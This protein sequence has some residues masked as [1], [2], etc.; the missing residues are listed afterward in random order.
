MAKYKILSLVL[1][2]QYIKVLGMS[3]LFMSYHG[4]QDAIVGP[5]QPL[6]EIL[7]IGSIIERSD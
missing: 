1:S 2:L 3:S 6:I 4:V 5:A 7:K